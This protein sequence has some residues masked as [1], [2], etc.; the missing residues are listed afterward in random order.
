M[1]GP[2]AGGA[3]RGAALRRP[4]GLP[5]AG[6][7]GR[8]ASRD[9]SAPSGWTWSSAPGRRRGWCRR[10]VDEEHRETVEHRGEMRVLEQRSPWGVLRFG[11]LGQPL[12]QHLLPYARTLPL[13]LFAPPDLRGAKAGVPP[14][15]LPLPLPRGPAGLSV[16]QG[17]R[18]AQHPPCRLPIHLPAPSQG[19]PGRRRSGGCGPGCGGSCPSTCTAR[20]RWAPPCTPRPTRCS[21]PSAWRPSAPTAPPSPRRWHTWV[22]SCARGVT[23][24]FWGRWGESFY[25]AGAARLPVVPLAEDDVRAAL[26]GAGFTLRALRSYAMPPALRTGVDDV[27]GVF[28]AHAQKPLEA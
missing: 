19:S 2:S 16:A 25:L 23:F 10:E 3:K 15:P 4:P 28:F 13:P 5:R 9:P 26:A 27:D 20:S 11:F 8:G 21:R 1:L 14:H 18:A 17:G 24:Y 6:G 7:G 12:A 22:P